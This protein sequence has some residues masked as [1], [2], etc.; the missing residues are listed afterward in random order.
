[1]EENEVKIYNDF[2]I[3]PFQGGFRYLLTNE[4]GQVTVDCHQFDSGFVVNHMRAET[5]RFSNQNHVGEMNYIMIDVTIRG[6]MAISGGGSADSLFPG[7]TLIYHPMN[8]RAFMEVLTESYESITVGIDLNRFCAEE[9][10]PEAKGLEEFASNPRSMMPFMLSG[11]GMA[12]LSAIRAMITGSRDDGLMHRLVSDLVTEARSCQDHRIKV[13]SATVFKE[14][15]D[16]LYDSLASGGSDQDIGRRCEELGIDKYNINRKFRC[17][18]GVTPYALYKKMRLW[19]AAARL[20]LSD[21]PIGEVAKDAGYLKE[22]KFASAFSK[23]VGCAPRSFRG[24]YR[25]GRAAK[26]HARAVRRKTNSHFV[27]TF[28]D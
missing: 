5:R 20:I 23:E 25:P 12:I 2:R 18:Y 19:D 9:G 24:E 10:N 27:S 8:V 3:T 17:S 13:H 16:I 15:Q 21:D 22:G 26:D 11:R 14:P 4:G 28:I 7:R 6:R 1:M